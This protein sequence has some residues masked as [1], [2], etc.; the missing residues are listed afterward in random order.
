MLN[1]GWTYQNKIRY[2]KTHG[3][4]NYDFVKFYK[5]DDA[6]DEYE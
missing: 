5:N 1:S 3:Y 2:Y 6:D 4:D